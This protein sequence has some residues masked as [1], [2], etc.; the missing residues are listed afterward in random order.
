MRHLAS[1]LALACIA[2]LGCTSVDA[3]TRKV[4]TRAS[5]DLA[6]PSEQVRVVRLDDDLWGSGAYGATGCGKRISYNVA[7]AAIGATCQ[8]AAQAASD[9]VV[10]EQGKQ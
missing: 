10:R 8:I 3:V 7:C 6:C 1:G 9:A 4:S 2:M 5:F